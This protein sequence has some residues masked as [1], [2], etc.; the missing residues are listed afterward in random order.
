MASQ[1]LGTK[2]CVALISA[3]A[4]ALP[5][6]AGA[7]AKPAAAGAQA[8][9]QA[10]LNE[11]IK[12]AKAEGQ[13]TFY[14]AATENVG[15]RIADAF[16]AKYGVKTQFVRLNSIALQARYATEAEAGTFAAD[17][18]FNS[19]DAVTY[20]LNGIKKGWIEPLGA[21]P[22]VISGEFPERFN[23]QV[24]A[25]VNISPWSIVYNTDKVKGA[26][27]PKD[28]PDLLKPKWKGQILAPDPRASD[29][30]MD[31][32]SL[33][34]DRYGDKFFAQLREQNVRY[35][36]SGVPALQALAAGEGSIMV[37]VVLAQFTATKA[38]GAPIVF[39]TPDY[40]VGNEIQVTLTHRSKAKRPNA[41][42]LL[43]NYAM[44]REGNKVFNDDPGQPTMYDTGMLPKEYHSA[45]PGTV[46]RK[47]EIIKLLG[48]Q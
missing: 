16:Q 47:P 39:F 22:V 32:W 33:L 10:A 42:R 20:A 2:S 26:D 23:R 48:V 18:I 30:Y 4:L 8:Q 7:P 44:S 1:S 17:L 34:H 28:W 40:A 27:I 19:G 24:T 3:L 38:K 15:R 25:V 21:L 41:A 43:A 9:A 37:P 36:T 35:F 5:A 29:S 31:H 12:A 14:T 46:A 45:K 11:L 13:I 6:I